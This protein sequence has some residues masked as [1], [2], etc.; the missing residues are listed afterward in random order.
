MPGYVREAEVAAIEAVRQ[1][2][3]IEAKEVEQ[4]GVEIVDTD[5]IDGGFVP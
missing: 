5:P 3:V 4:R 1:L 2:L